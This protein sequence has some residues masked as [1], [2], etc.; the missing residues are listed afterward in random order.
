MSCFTYRT[1]SLEFGGDTLL[2]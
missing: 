1:A 2:Y